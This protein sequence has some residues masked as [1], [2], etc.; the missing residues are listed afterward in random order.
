MS[1]VATRQIRCKTGRRSG[2]WTSTQ[3]S[4][5]VHFGRSNRMIEY[6]IKGKTLG[7]V[8]DQKG[9]GVQVLRTLKAVSQVK[10]VVKVAY[11]ILAFIEQALRP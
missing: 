2:R 3:I 10:A 9:L 11:G 5:V 8:K 4:A 6:N 1:A 7:S